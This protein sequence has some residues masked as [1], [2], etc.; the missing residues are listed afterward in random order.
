MTNKSTRVPCFDTAPFDDWVVFDLETTGLSPDCDEIIQI[1]AVR[2]VS[3]R[4]V[5]DDA[6]FSYV[7]P[8]R[9]VPSFITSYT[10]VTQRDVDGA[11]GPGEVLA[12]FSAYCGGSLL[13]AHN[14][15]R[16]DVPFVST[17]CVRGGL[18]TRP[19]PFVDSMHLSW[20]L[21]GRPKG[22]SHSLDSVIDRL[23][24]R[25][26]DIRRH[27]ARGDMLVT[28][29]CVRELVGRLN[30]REEAGVEM[31]QCPL[32]RAGKTSGRSRP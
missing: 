2:L 23:G 18:R 24:V 10:G 27:D 19:N 7:K 25:S 30:D 4:I 21:W 26:D 22:L 5:E 20:A 6:F 11:P 17:A 15:R 31:T 8:T 32:P 9:P 14:G 28:A 1:A 13:S 3:G 29:R 12:A 16:F